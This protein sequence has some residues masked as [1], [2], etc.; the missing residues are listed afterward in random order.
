MLAAGLT[1]LVAWAF[2]VCDWDSSHL[3]PIAQR[4]HL[5][6]SPGLQAQPK[7][8]HSCACPQLCPWVHVRISKNDLRPSC[9]LHLPALLI[10]ARR[11][12]ALPCQCGGH[13]P[14]CAVTTLSYELAL[15][16]LLPDMGTLFPQFRHA[17][18]HSAIRGP[19]QEVSS[20]C[21]L[22]H[23]DCLNQLTSCRNTVCLSSFL[24][25]VLKDVKEIAWDGQKGQTHT[26]HMTVQAF[27][28]V[29]SYVICVFFSCSL[30]PL[31]FK[32]GKLLFLP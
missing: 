22:L 12:G 29:I 13:C 7:L 8:C 23:K 2:A 20:H 27:K 4:F 25:I 18:K 11:C 19:R 15:L 1:A 10:Q 14:S 31:C 17:K 16:L 3:L 21:R 30:S 6:S 32:Q 26:Y 5:N 28:E 9:C 24:Q